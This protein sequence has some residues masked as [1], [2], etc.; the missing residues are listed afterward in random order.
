MH[1]VGG[2][3]DS[4]VDPAKFSRQLCKNIDVLIDN[5]ADG[6]KYMTDP[7]Q[8]MIDAVEQSRE[9]GSST[10][11]IASLDKEQARL[12]TANLGD[13]GYLLLRKNGLDLVSVFRTKEQTHSFN[14]P[15]QVGTSGDDPSSADIHV[16]EIYHNDILVIGTDGL[17]DNLFD[18]RI[19]ELIKPFIRG[20]DDILDPDLLAEIIA[21]EAE[22]FSRNQSYMSPFAKSAREAFYDYIGGKQDDIT[23]AVC[24][25]KLAPKE[26]DKVTIEEPIDV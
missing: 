15:F 21:N 24:Q 22:K 3:A 19:V 18:V 11:V 13:S 4:G 17:F 6:H 10:C 20:R 2:W 25:V 26:T 12:H 8:L 5:D 1:G 16:H 14:F 7:R 23:V 9:I